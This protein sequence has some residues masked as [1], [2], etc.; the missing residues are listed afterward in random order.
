MSKC[1]PQNDQCAVNLIIHHKNLNSNFRNTNI[2]KMPCAWYL[3]IEIAGHSAYYFK[4]YDEE[5]IRKH[6][7]TDE[8][9]SKRAQDQPDLHREF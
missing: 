5:K 2:C 9:R 6:K 1:K 8:G 7:K 4:K 3:I